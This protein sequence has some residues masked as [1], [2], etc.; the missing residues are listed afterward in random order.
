[1]VYLVP[2]K[3]VIS[4]ATHTQECLGKR[5]CTCKTITKPQC[6]VLQCTCPAEDR[7]A[8]QCDI[9]TSLAAPAVA[10]LISLFIELPI[11]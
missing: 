1:M 2:G 3:K 5:H 11:I 10:G 9:G 6:A 7:Q 8:L 4:P